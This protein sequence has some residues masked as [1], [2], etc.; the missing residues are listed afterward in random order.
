MLGSERGVVEEWLSEFKA[1]PE[2]QISSYAATLHRKKTLVP[3]LYKVI[4]DPNNELL[5]PV[6][7]Q[8]FELYRSSEVRLKR[9]TLQFLPELIWVYLRLTASRDR[10]SNGCIEALLL[11]IY[12]LEIADK[13]GNNKVLSFTI[14]SLSKPSIYHEPS[15]I[16]SMALTEGALCQHDLIRVV[17]SDLHPQRE[18]FTAQNRF[19]VLSFL[20]LCY[21]SAIVYMPASSYQSLCRMGSRLCVS[22]FPRQHQKRWK[23]HCGRVVLDPDF[24]VQLLTG[25]Y[26]A[27]YNGQWDLGQEVLEDIIYRAQLELYSQPLLV[28]NAMKNSLPFDAPDASQEGQ[29]VLKVEVTPT[30]PRISRTAITTASIRRHR[31]RREDAEGVNG[32]EESVNLNDADEGFSSGASLSSQSVGTKPQS[33]VSQKGSV[34]KTASGCSAKDKETSSAGKSN[35][36]PRDSVARK[37]YIHQSTDLGTDIIEM[38]PTKKHLSLPAG[39]VVPKAN[40]L[41]LIRT[42]SASSSK[43]FDYVNGSQTG[44]SVGIGTEGV[45]NLATGN[46]N[47]FSTISLQEDRL[48]QAGE[49]IKV[50]KDKAPLTVNVKRFVKKLDTLSDDE[51][52][53]FLEEKDY[54]AALGIRAQDSMENGSSI[55]GGEVYSFQTP[56]CSN[57]M[58]ELASELAQTPGQSVASDHSECPEKATKTPQS[59]KHSSS[60]KV[61]QKSKK[62]DFVST[63]P[64]RLRKRLAAPDAYLES[65]SEYSASCSEEEDDEETQKEVSTVLS[66]QKTPAKAKVASIPPS[67]KKVTKKKDKM[68]NLVVEYFEAHSSSKVLTSDRTLQK[69][70]KRRLNQQT[71]HDLLEKSPLAYAAEIEEL[72]QQYESLFSKW[73]LQLHLGFNIVLYGLGSKHDLLEKFRISMLQDSVHLVV[74]GYFPSITVRSILNSITEEVLDHIGTFRS[75]LDQLEFIIKRFKE[76]SSLELYVLI[77]NLDSQMLRGERSQQILAQLSSLPSVYLIASID[78]INAPLMWDQAK[79]SL[80]NWL[81]YETTTFSPYVEETSYENSLLVQ[82]S[83]SLALSSLMHVLR[84]LTLNARGIFRLLAQYQLENKDNPSYPGL[85][86]QDFYQQCREAFLVNS[87]L[88]LRAQLTEF[89]D[90]K[91]IRTKRGADGVEYLLIPVDDNTLTDFLEKEDE[92]V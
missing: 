87:D 82:Q 31:W 29:K 89:R 66:S 18:T 92:D 33:S 3:A 22:G 17:Y 36:S 81:W 68:S 84:S 86:F 59:S 39:Q 43:S 83:G 45:T 47:R 75:P 90:H 71:L 23:E 6:C 20:M 12:N 26:Y 79:Q 56:K 85:S 52:Q 80:Y 8:L 74:N 19:E 42:A 32:R 44:S 28:A 38:T 10:Q 13:D 88:T 51:A 11:G 34:R 1:L 41:S 14:P 65:E 4:Q 48:G 69:L 49:G 25:V 9:F 63:T 91:L 27:I 76:D 78:H 37:Q 16:G 46:S 50:R 15:T 24:M 2:T 21:N 55:G 70:R 7:H 30:V 73:M 77:H 61:Q 57:K 35:E 58:A 62:N 60:N 64:Y 72:N 5:E 54:V 67:R 40:S 53:E